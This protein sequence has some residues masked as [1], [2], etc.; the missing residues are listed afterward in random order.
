MR[1]WFAIRNRKVNRWCRM[2]QKCSLF[3]GGAGWAR[4]LSELPPHFSRRAEGILWK[5]TIRCSPPQTILRLLFSQGFKN[6]VPDS[7]FFPPTL[8]SSLKVSWVLYCG[9]SYQMLLGPFSH[10]MRDRTLCC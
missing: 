1:K 6:S 10:K 2:L 7:F 3:L 9:T 4:L 5:N 8:K